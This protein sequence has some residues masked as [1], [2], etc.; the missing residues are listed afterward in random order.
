MVVVFVISPIKS[1]LF[2]FGEC[3][4]WLLIDCLFFSFCYVKKYVKIIT[5]VLFTLYGVCWQFVL[6]SN[7]GLCCS[8][9][10][11]QSC[12]ACPSR[13]G[14]KTCS[15]SVCVCVCVCVCLE[16]VG[17]GLSCIVWCFQSCSACP[18][19]TRPR[20]RDCWRSWPMP[21]SMRTCPSGMERLRSS[22]R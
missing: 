22:D 4:Y 21:Q 19:T 7:Y 14:S 18:S 8:A 20:S 16:L 1:S 13:P 5:N 2:L 9:W 10:C 12:S 15:N 11:V 17:T 3:T 6:N